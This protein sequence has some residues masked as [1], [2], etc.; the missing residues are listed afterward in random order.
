MSDSTGLVFPW[1]HDAMTGKE[2]PDGLRSPE[3]ILYLSL[4]LLYQ[5]HRLKMISR[6]TAVAEKKRLV[7]EYEMD[8]RDYKGQMYYINQMRMSKK[9][10]S[11][12]RLNRTLENADLLADVVDGLEEFPEGGFPVEKTAL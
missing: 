5:Q 8:K 3:Q 2:M 9:A 7:K 4:R 1:E 11:R 6:E 12:Y 10:C